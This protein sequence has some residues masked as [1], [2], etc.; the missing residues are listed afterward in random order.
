[1]EHVS[2]SLLW[3]L[4]PVFSGKSL[5]FSWSNKLSIMASTNFLERKWFL[6]ATINQPVQDYKICIKPFPENKYYK[7]EFL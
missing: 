1:M 7:G 5:V 3:V 2:L 4:S 6:H